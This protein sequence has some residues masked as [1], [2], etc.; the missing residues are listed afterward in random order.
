MII[1]NVI[2]RVY[3]VVTS[4]VFVLKLHSLLVSRHNME[5]TTNLKDTSAHDHRYITVQASCNLSS[6]R[7]LF[8]NF[9]H[10]AHLK[11]V[12]AT[13]QRS[14]SSFTTV[15]VLRQA[16][17]N[18]LICNQS[19]YHFYSY[20]LVVCT[21]H[22]CTSLRTIKWMLQTLGEN[23]RLKNVALQVQCIMQRVTNSCGCP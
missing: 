9:P 12:T 8:G 21:P 23:W 15:Q 14:S 10:R 22:N 20:L 6:V 13:I 3:Y 18:Q 5:F 1:A 16:A 4:E 11:H 2:Y 7:S 17:G 19:K